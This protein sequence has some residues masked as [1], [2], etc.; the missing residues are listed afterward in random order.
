MIKLV[1]Q[2]RATHDLEEIE[3]F[4]FNQFGSAAAAEYMAKLER[5]FDRL[6]LYP[7]SGPLYP[8]AWPPVRHTRSG[9]HY[10]FYDYDGLSVSVIR[11]LHHARVPDDFF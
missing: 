2:P 11:I 3:E 7:E 1:L 5:V 4:S 9:Q 10:V 8:D 6:A